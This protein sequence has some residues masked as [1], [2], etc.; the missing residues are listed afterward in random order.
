MSYMNTP[1]MAIFGGTKETVVKLIISW[2][3]N[4][5]FYFDKL[6]E[7]SSDLI[8]KLTGLSNQGNPVP[9]GIKDGL[10]EQLEGTP[11]G[12][13]SKGLMIS[14]IQARTVQ[15]ASKIIAT[16]LTPIG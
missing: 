4:G 9:I 16:G 6:V 10:V 11:S 14:Q 15:I 3:H 7:I 5:K 8:Y 1:F 2:Y 13:N 12:K